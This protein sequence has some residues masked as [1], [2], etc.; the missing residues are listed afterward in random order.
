[1]YCFSD[2]PLMKKIAHTVDSQSPHRILLLAN[3]C[4]KASFQLKALSPATA[5]I[6][7]QRIAAFDVVVQVV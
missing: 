5:G 4:G 2:P 7:N 3:T 6:F 1:M